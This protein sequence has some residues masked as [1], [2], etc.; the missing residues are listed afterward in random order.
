MKKIKFF[1]YLQNDKNYLR[2]NHG[3]TY[4]EYFKINEIS[5][6]G[7]RVAQNFIEGLIGGTFVISGEKN[8]CR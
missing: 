6:R 1:F 5:V 7:G 4:V 2:K 8:F 3:K